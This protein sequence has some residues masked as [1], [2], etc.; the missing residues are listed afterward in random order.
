MPPPGRAGAGGRAA[1]QI[2]TYRAQAQQ[3]QA[4]LANAQITLSDTDIY[5]PN[6]G[7]VVKK[8]ANVGASLSPGQTIFTMTQGD[9]VWVEAN[10][11]ETQ[12]KDVGPAD[13][14]LEVDAF[15]GKMFKGRVRSINEATGAA[16]SLLPPDNATGNFTKVVQRIPVRIELDAASD[17]RRR[18]IRPREGHSQFAAGHVRQR[19]HRYRRQTISQE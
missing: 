15:P 4:A 11:K 18:Q 2:E 3:A 6:D 14:E 5:A 7:I 8:T 10:F 9:Y 17:R 12:L 1:P 19:H 13:A 16:T